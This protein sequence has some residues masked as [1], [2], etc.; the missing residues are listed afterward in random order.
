MGKSM[1]IV[2]N[3]WDSLFLNIIYLLIIVLIIINLPS[4]ILL[5]NPCIILPVC[6][7]LPEA[8][9]SHIVTN[10]AFNKCTVV[11]YYIT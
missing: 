8:E 3:I 1:F 11:E 7:Q 5:A 10:V 4:I 2:V 6:L 9:R